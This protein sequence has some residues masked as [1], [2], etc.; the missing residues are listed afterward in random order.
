MVTVAFTS[1]PWMTT[2]LM[3]SVVLF[4]FAYSVIFAIT[5][6]RLISLSRW[7]RTWTTG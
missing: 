1:T 7:C 3:T 2:L 4:F 6:A 5:S